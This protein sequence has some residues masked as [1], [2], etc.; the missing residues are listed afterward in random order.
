MSSAA[1]PREDRPNGHVQNFRRVRPLELTPPRDLVRHNHANVLAE[2]LGVPEIAG[3]SVQ[4][5][6]CA[7]FLPHRK[8]KVR[9]HGYLFDTLSFARP[10]RS[11]TGF[12]SVPVKRRTRAHLAPLLAALHR[13]RADITA[14][15]GARGGSEMR[16]LKHLSRGDYNA[17]KPKTTTHTSH[18]CLRCCA[19][20]AGC[21]RRGFSFTA[22]H[23]QDPPSRVRDPPPHAPTLE[24]TL[25]LTLEP[26]REYSP[27]LLTDK[28]WADIEPTKLTVFHNPA[29]ATSTGVLAALNDA[30]VLYPR[31]PGLRN[32]CGPLSL[33]ITVVSC[34][35]NADEFREI[36]TH[37]SDAPGART[38]FA[39]FLRP[40]TNHWP[41][42]AGALAA[43]VEK[44]PT[45]LTWP[46]VVDWERRQSSLG[47]VLASSVEVSSPSTIFGR[48]S[49]APFPSFSP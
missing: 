17:R 1:A 36:A 31:Q 37:I 13:A 23:A 28:Q 46:V 16:A 42:S 44:D 48:V 2:L 10:T 24:L 19:A 45:L 26:I 34:P 40:T 6:A 14:T 4:F 8:K 47:G 3:D 33:D 43:L 32:A 18:S 20:A 27:P 49:P 9:D 35:P 41:T 38:S 7:F 15:G 39:A 30:A 5:C 22:L 21:S 11:C 25:E 29:D 12:V